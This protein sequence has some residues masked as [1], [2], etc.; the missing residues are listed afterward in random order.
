MNLSLSNE[1]WDYR[2]LIISDT[3]QTVKSSMRRL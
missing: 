3:E 1:M 2:L